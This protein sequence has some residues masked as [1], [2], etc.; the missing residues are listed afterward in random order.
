MNRELIAAVLTVIALPIFA[1]DA[2]SDRVFF[3][4]GNWT[5]IGPDLQRELRAKWVGPA[6]IRTSSALD[7]SDVRWVMDY[8]ALSEIVN[9]R[10]CDTLKLLETR[11]FDMEVDLAENRPDA[12]PGR[13]DYAWII[14]TCG[15]R[16]IYRVMNMEGESDLT[17]Y[18]TAP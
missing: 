15:S 10:D 17:V 6:V 11:P 16:H 5:E 4:N 9:Y 12:K 14:D 2:R 3:I 8:I 18:Q 13:F 7:A 1:D